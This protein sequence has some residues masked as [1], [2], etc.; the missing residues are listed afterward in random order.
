MFPLY[1]PVAVMTN[2][3]VYVLKNISVKSYL[4][5]SLLVLNISLYI[6]IQPY[7]SAAAMATKTDQRIFYFSNVQGGRG[8]RGEMDQRNAT[9]V[10]L[11]ASV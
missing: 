4:R 1:V 2:N 9:K 7:T 8:Q 10:F 6:F 11:F 5:W 3:I